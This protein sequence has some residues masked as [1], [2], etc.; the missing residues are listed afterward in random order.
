MFR[1]WDNEKCKGEIYIERKT[2]VRKIRLT[3]T[4]WVLK[5]NYDNDDDDAN[6]RDRF[7]TLFVLMQ[8]VEWWWW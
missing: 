2:I 3:L 6:C 1:R 8:G 4:C 7:K 5:D